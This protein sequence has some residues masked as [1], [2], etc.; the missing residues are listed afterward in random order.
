MYSMKL[1]RLFSA[2]FCFLF[3]LFILESSSPVWAAE[4]KG[5]G[6]DFQALLDESIK[7]KAS[8][9]DGLLLISRENTWDELPVDHEEMV[10]CVDEDSAWNPD[11]SGISIVNDIN[12]NSNPHGENDNFTLTYSGFF[13]AGT[14][15]EWKFSTNSDDASELV[16]DGRVV[17]SWYGEHGKSGY[18]SDHSGTVRLEKGWHHVIYRMVEKTGDQFSKVVFYAPDTKGWYPF[19]TRYLTLKTYPLQDGILLINQKNTRHEHPQ[20]HDE[21][22]S[23]VEIEAEANIDYFGWRVVDAIEHAE[24]IHGLDH[25]YTSRYEGYFEVTEETAGEWQFAVNSGSSSEL[26]INGQIVSSWYGDHNPSASDMSHSGTI[27]LNPGIHFLIYRQEVKDGTPLARACYMSPGATEWNII[28]KSSLGMKTYAEDIDGDGLANDLEA[29][30]GTDVLNPDT[31]MEGL[32]DFTEAILDSDPKNADSNGDG[33]PDSVEILDGNWDPDNDGEDNLWDNDNDNDGVPD[34]LD[35]SPFARS[36]V[37]NEFHFE[38]GTRGKPTYL[39][40]QIRP[41]NPMNLMLLGKKW[42]WPDNDD[43]GQMQDRD[44]SKE[45]VQII[46]MLELTANIQPNQDNVEENGIYVTDETQLRALDGE[47]SHNDGMGAGNVLGNSDKEIVVA[48]DM[49]HKI[50]IRDNQGNILSQFDCVFVTDDRLMVADILGDSMDEIIV[51]HDDDS[52]VYVYSGEGQLITVNNVGYHKEARVAAG[53]IRG[54][55]KAE[56]IVP[57]LISGHVHT[58]GFIKDGRKW[59]LDHRTIDEENLYTSDDGLAAAD[60]DGDG[61]DEILVAHDVDD[62]LII[63][64]Y[65]QE[66]SSWNKREKTRLN[67][68]FDKYDGLTGAEV[69]KSNNPDDPRYGEEILCLKPDGSI[70]VYT[71]ASTSQEKKIN[72]VAYSEFDGY[73]GTD[74]M[75]NEMREIIVSSDTSGVV[76]IYNPA[77]RKSYVPLSQVLDDG[78]PVAYQGRMIYEATGGDITLMADARLVWF[79]IGQ[80]DNEDDPDANET[81]VLSKYTEDFQI[82]GFTATEYRSIDA[83]LFYKDDIDEPG[84]AYMHLSNDF[85]YGQYNLR[86]SAER[87]AE[88]TSVNVDDVFPNNELTHQ[89]ETDKWIDDQL[90]NTVLANLPDGEFPVVMGQETAFVAIAMEDF[91]DNGVVTGNRFTSDMTTMEERLSRTVKMNWYDTSL[92]SISP[93]TLEEIEDVLKSLGHSDKT[94]E[95]EMVNYMLACDAEEFVRNISESHK[96]MHSGLERTGLSIAFKFGGGLAA[97]LFQ[98]TVGSN[99][100]FKTI[101]IHL[102]TKKAFLNKGY[103]FKFKWA[104]SLKQAKIGQ[105]LT[106][107]GKFNKFITPLKKFGGAFVGIAFTAYTFCSI[108]DASGWSSTG[109]KI[110]GLYAGLGAGYFAIITIIGSCGPPGAIIAGLIVISDLI[111]WAITGEGWSDRIMNWVVGKLVDIHNPPDIDLNITETEVVVSD[112]EGNG[113]DV[114]D[115]I[116]F[117][118]RAKEIIKKDKDTEKADV[119]DSYLKPYANFYESGRYNDGSYRHIISNSLT[120]EKRERVW[121]FGA[122]VEPKSADTDFSAKVHLKAE[123]KIYYREDGRKS[124]TKNYDYGDTTITFDVMPGSLEDFLNWSVLV[125]LENDD[126]RLADNIEEGS[127]PWFRIVNKEKTDEADATRAMYST[128]PGVPAISGD[129]GDGGHWRLEQGVDGSYLL[130]NDNTN[131]YLIYEGDTSSLSLAP[132]VSDDFGRWDLDP[133]ID[134]LYFISNRGHSESEDIRYCLAS[135]PEGGD[136][137]KLLRSRDAMNEAMWRLAVT[138]S[139]TNAYITDTD[140]DGISD[141]YEINY[142]SQGI[143]LDATKPDTD[144]DGLTDLEELEQET[145]PSL[146]DTDDD[147]LNDKDELNGWLVRLKYNSLVITKRVA[148]DP[149]NPDSD[150]D[151]LSD[152]EEKDAQPPLNPESRDTDGDGIPDPDDDDPLNPPAGMTDTDFDRLS[153]ETETTGWE[154]TVVT[155]EGTSKRTVKSNP[156]ME[157]SDGD[158]IPDREEYNISDPGMVDTDLDGL[159]DSTE[160]SCG[161]D[162]THFD[163]DLDGLSDGSEKNTYFTDPMDPDTDNDGISD[164]NEI[165]L[166]GSNPL[167]NDSDNDGIT[168]ADE[169]NITGTDPAVSDSD[170]DGIDDGSEIDAWFTDPLDADS[171][172][173][174][175]TDGEE[176]LIYHTDP[177]LKDTDGDGIN[178]EIEAKKL[179]DV[180]SFPD[181]IDTDQDGLTDYEERYI[182]NTIACSSDSDNDGLKDGEEISLGTDPLLSDSDGDTLKDGEEVNTYQTNPMSMDTDSDSLSDNIELLG[183]GTNPTEADTDGDGINDDMDPDSSPITIEKALVLYDDATYELKQ[184]KIDGFIA[185]LDNFVGTVDSGNPLDFPDKSDYYFIVIIARPEGFI[186]GDGS[187][188]EMTY[189]LTDEETRENMLSHDWYRFAVAAVSEYTGLI[190]FSGNITNPVGNPPEPQPGPQV[191]MGLKNSLIVM[192]TEPYLYDVSRTISRFMSLKGLYH[193][194]YVI[195][196]YTTDNIITDPITEISLDGVDN[197]GARIENAILSADCGFVSA[198]LVSF[199][200]ETSP[201]VL[202]TGNGLMEGLEKVGKYLLVDVRGFAIDITGIQTESLEDTLSDAVIRIYYKSLELDRSYPRD[203]DITDI[204]DFDETTLTVYFYDDATETWSEIVSNVYTENAT[205]SDVEYEGYLE[206]NTSDTGLFALAAER[207]PD[208]TPEGPPEVVNN[209]PVHDSNNIAP[210]TPINFI[211]NEEVIDIDLS[212]IYIDGSEITGAALE[213]DNR[214][215]TISHDTL[216]PGITFTVTIPANIVC[217]YAGNLNSYEYSWSF[218]TQNKN[219]IPFAVNDLFSTDQNAVVSGNIMADN[220][221]GEDWDTEDDSLVVTM[222]NNNSFSLNTP[223]SGSE[224]GVFIVMEDG[225][226]SFDPNNEFDDLSEN[227]TRETSIT[228][229]LSDGMGTASAKVTVIVSGLNDPPELSPDHRFLF[230][231]EEDAGDDDES[232]ND[233]DDDM[234]DNLNNPGTDVSDILKS[235]GVVNDIDGDSIGIALTGVIHTNGVWQ[236]TTDT[237]TWQEIESSVTMDNAILLD[238][239]DRVRFVPEPDH[240]GIENGRIQFSAWDRSEGFAGE[241]GYN[242][243]AGDACSENEVMGFVD[244]LPLENEIAVEVIKQGEAEGLVTGAPSGIDCGS[245]CIGTYIEGVNVT[246]TAVPANE[247]SEFAGWSRPDCPEAGECTFA[248]ESDITVYAYFV[249]RDSDNDGTADLYDAFPSDPSE[250][251]DTDGD[252]TGDNS[253]EDIDNDGIPNS[254]EITH[255]LNPYVDD[256]DEDPDDDELSNYEEF[257]KGSDPNILTTGPGVAVLIYPSEMSID[258]SIIPD[259]EIGYRK[260]ENVSGHKSTHWQIALDDEFTSMVMDITS[261]R[262][263]TFLP[264]P[265]GILNENTTYYWRAQFIDED[266]FNWSFPLPFYFVTGNEHMVDDNM[267]NIPDAQEVLP[268]SYLDLDNDGENDLEQANMKVITGSDGNILVAFKAGDNVIDIE[269]LKRMEPD[270]ISGFDNPPASFPVG[271]YCFRFTVSNPGDEATVTVYFSEPLPDNSVWFKG[272]CIDGWVDYSGYAT[273]SDDRKSVDIDFIDGGF[274]DSDST[275]NGIIVD[276]S[277]PVIPDITRHDSSACFISTAANGLKKESNDYRIL[278][279]LIILLFVIKL[280]KIRRYQK[281]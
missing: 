184:E 207:F 280:T 160:H 243:I 12:H 117:Q 197:T 100:M 79:V 16:I 262:F 231:V 254:W 241:T 163:T 175:L 7:S 200:E 137:V 221:E 39:D 214:T 226:M 118:C 165:N 83:A 272:N 27:T 267:N 202:D 57:H 4:K 51:F 46:P 174:N 169:V 142:L 153:D 17:T 264:V 220:S 172:D 263:L 201:A 109:M 176:V 166:Y 222:V 230:S 75:G 49:D 279:P 253:D 145:N 141:A 270:E 124:K 130:L 47:F 218:T 139:P 13:Y 146:E 203:G 61:I 144:S 204:N 9:E 167:A 132:S 91:I 266:D 54:D 240:Y 74:F 187:A 278:I 171:D 37:N 29:I 20:N 140:G 149:V 138:K 19:S 70:R 18:Y 155:S 73:T 246:L 188:A 104:E 225:T 30:L 224:G 251:I 48:W 248:A 212:Q 42:D 211:F 55:E 90:H 80:T 125:P 147:G 185:E 205:I 135:D 271:V 156:E 198:S 181:R 35:S 24:N 258:Q 143:I 274:G 38:I 255:N 208:T 227:L 67:F 88:S 131:M 259:L 199:V 168:D 102:G 161:T 32:N 178:D 96:K 25:D 193:D 256:A 242:T 28:K 275:P 232:S 122:W 86:E 195:E 50:S 249:Y 245:Q 111:T 154:I 257:Q 36:E 236:Y 68:D 260:N 276:P 180:C 182:Y 87:I 206:I 44:N 3:I 273:I 69:L 235:A 158:S 179:D 114:G 128:G 213:P 43:K 210:D 162:V 121:E 14:E 110:G 277:G 123:M 81:T 23:C 31:D 170:G 228:Y 15:G 194:N 59:A 8:L 22:L 159:E 148:P 78:I 164:G 107:L 82:T 244:V 53:N 129:T 45:D 6:L 89:W 5:I 41:Q 189:L 99:V 2:I 247:Y 192:L 62:L 229:S 85:L 11:R 21:L 33:L 136:D 196:T 239:D 97:A 84:N 250:V 58:F 134:D 126:D 101:K 191:D 93:M 217:D 1:Y 113:L 76:N 281:P 71:E 186:E 65:F 60:V 252:G 108:A 265:D 116:E 223:V 105:S 233:N 92:D 119:A 95:I 52:S 152:K 151:G 157:D 64:E 98:T 94:I 269:F 234:I 133:V 150:G 115:R 209:Y 261:S 34:G 66:G 237:V 26:E 190:S 120:D 56:I 173:D 216:S 63:W 10:R 106:K 183:L 103:Q 77:Y 238:P 72:D 219:N 112:Y 127:G 177:N 40:F 215:I 268:G